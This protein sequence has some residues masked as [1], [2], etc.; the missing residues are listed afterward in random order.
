MLSPDIPL[1]YRTAKP[2]ELA[3]DLGRLASS[4]VAW[5]KGL[6][7][8][9]DS[10]PE[11]GKLAPDGSV[12]AFGLLARVAPRDGQ[13]IQLKLP[14]PSPRDGG[15]S[16]Q[17]ARLTTDGA[18]ELICAGFTVNGFDRLLLLGSIG[19]STITTDGAN[20]FMDNPGALNWGAGLL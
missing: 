2:D 3:N 6:P 19:I 7:S 1:R 18:V 8:A 16:L 5:A 20:Y 10:L 14:V 11:V 4:I 12:L 13:W 15:R 9:R 17:V